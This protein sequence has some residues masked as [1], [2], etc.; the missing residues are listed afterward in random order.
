MCMNY[1]SNLR[2]SH[3]F[4]QN[5][6]YGKLLNAK[7]NS[8][9]ILLRYTFISYSIFILLHLTRNNAYKISFDH[10]KFK[11]FVNKLANYKY[12]IRTSGNQ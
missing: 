9:K 7:S 6:Q 11:L 10:K 8:M 12:L 2:F 1:G 5:K 4:I 3:S